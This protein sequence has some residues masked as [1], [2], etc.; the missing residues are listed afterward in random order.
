MALLRTCQVIYDEATSFLY[1]SNTFSFDDEWPSDWADAARSI[2]DPYLWSRLATMHGFLKRI[3]PRNVRKLRHVRLSFES[4]EFIMNVNQWLRPFLP[5][6][7]G[8]C[9]LGKALDLL[10]ANHNLFTLDLAFIARGGEWPP[11]PLVDFMGPGGLLR[12][13]LA[14]MKGVRGLRLFVKATTRDMKA[15]R[16]WP[17]LLKPLKQE[18]MKPFLEECAETTLQV[19]LRQ[20]RIFKKRPI[21]P[22]SHLD[23]VGQTPEVFQRAPKKERKKKIVGTEH[24]SE[25]LR[26]TD[27]P[28]MGRGSEKI[29]SGT[30]RSVEEVEAVSEAGT[31]GTTA[32]VEAEVQGTTNDIETQ[33]VLERIHRGVTEDCKSHW[34]RLEK[35]RQWRIFFP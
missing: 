27:K 28:R 18:M 12:D 26:H 29:A 2:L 33:R 6:A 23:R 34:R 24:V 14:R 4:I 30:E 31:Q 13:E 20:R 16:G 17:R 7:G 9:C 5:P 35:N 11:R 21:F 25:A 10:S 3:K 19:P 32:D 15:Y 22:S 8:T 1:A